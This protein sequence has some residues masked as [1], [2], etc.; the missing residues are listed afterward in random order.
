MREIIG[1]DSDGYPITADIEEHESGYSIKGTTPFGGLPM[2]FKPVPKGYVGTHPN[3][4]GANLSSLVAMK[5][6]AVFCMGTSEW[7]YDYD[8]ERGVCI[9]YADIKEE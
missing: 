3:E 2:T 9:L 6:K 4:H 5:E 1:Y 8:L 7:Y